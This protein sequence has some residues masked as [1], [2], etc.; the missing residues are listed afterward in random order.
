MLVVIKKKQ[1]NFWMFILWLVFLSQWVY[2]AYELRLAM[3]MV[4]VLK[5]SE[6]KRDC[7]CYTD[8]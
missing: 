5:D 1:H 4:H 8:E 6:G 2:L 7:T 3:D